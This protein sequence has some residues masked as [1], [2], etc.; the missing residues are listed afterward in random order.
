MLR[1]SA[2]DQPG[3]RLLHRLRRIGSPPAGDAAGWRR[4]R[5]PPAD[6][7][8]RPTSASAPRDRSAAAPAHRVPATRA[9]DDAPGPPSDPSRRR[10]GVPGHECR[11]PLPERRR[12]DAAATDGCRGATASAASTASWLGGM[13]RQ[14]EKRQPLT[15]APRRGGVSPQAARTRDPAA[16]PDSAPRPALAIRATAPAAS[17]GHPAAARRRRRIEPPAAQSLI[18]DGR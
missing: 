10:I 17:G 15:A 14:P 2:V 6:G 18:I 1:S 4:S 11:Q 13:P 16:R 7:A 9:A 5:S 3:G 8:G 12:R